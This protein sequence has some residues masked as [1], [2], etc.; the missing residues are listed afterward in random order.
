MS[1]SCVR[2][3]R[4]GARDYHTAI[5]RRDIQELEEH[6]ARE[7]ESSSEETGGQEARS[8]EA[9]QEDHEEVGAR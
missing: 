6:D 4:S 2:W 5:Y 9:S 8:E 7:E 3:L 1:R